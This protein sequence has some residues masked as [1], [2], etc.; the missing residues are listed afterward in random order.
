MAVVWQPSGTWSVK[1]SHGRAT[2]FRSAAEAPDP[3]ASAENAPAGP[4]DETVTATTSELVGEY[5]AGHLRLLGSL[6]RYRVDNRVGDAVDSAS[7]DGRGAELEAEWQWQG[8][9]LRGSQAWQ[10]PSVSDGAPLV[11]APRRLTKLQ[12]SAPL[13]GEALRLSATVRHTGAYDNSMGRVPP[14]T[15]LD[16]TLVSQ[17]AVDGLDLRIGWRNVLQKR[18]AATDEYYWEPP[19]GYATRSAWIELTGTFR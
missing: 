17:K 8:W 9:R 13:M 5:R 6:Y 4:S 15:L 7:T 10:D 19:R 14:R 11:Y 16:L 18:E 2:L 12:A 3:D 1:A